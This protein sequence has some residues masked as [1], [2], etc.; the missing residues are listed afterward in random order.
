MFGA[1][2]TDAVPRQVPPSHGPF[3]VLWWEFVSQ[4]SQSETVTSDLRLRQALIGVLACLLTPGVLVTVNAL[5]EVEV[6]ARRAR[7]LHATGMIEP[8]LA[9]LASVLITYVMVAV[10]LIAVFE[11][12]ALAFDRRDAMLLGPLPLRGVTIVGAKLAALGTFLLAVSVSL[13]AL[14]VVPLALAAAERFGL[15]GFLRYAAAYLVA[16]I[17]AALFMGSVIVVVRGALAIVAGPHVAM[18]LGSLLQFLFVG[19][20]LTFM[21]VLF[22]AG[23][24]TRLLVFDAGGRFWMP[25]AR[26]LALVER[27]RGSTQPESI[28]FAGRAGLA[29][30]IAL[31]GAALVSIASFRR[32]TQLAPAP[33]ASVGA[34]AH[35]RV[36][37]TLVR[38]I[39]PATS[40]RGPPPISSFSPSRAVAP[41][42]G[43][44]QSTRPSASRS[45]SRD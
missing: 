24:Q 1:D 29:I 35:A 4:F 11:W 6:V 45:S 14:P 7:L 15:V 31:V 34:F 42:K 3:R 19:A 39:V 12:D 2:A 17:S 25:T 32:Q 20:L 38:L 27:I 41:S 33:A 10:G 30:P 9:V 5:T 18:R 28:A 21:L 22:I 23:R 40:S 37:R 44:S 16:S 13:N 43:G 8:L 26:F 36:G